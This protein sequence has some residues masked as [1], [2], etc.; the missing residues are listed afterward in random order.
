M[1]QSLTWI[2]ERQGNSGGGFLSTHPATDERIR[3]LQKL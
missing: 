2:L 1:I 3:A